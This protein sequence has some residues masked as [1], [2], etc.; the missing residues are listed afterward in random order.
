MIC[1]FNLMMPLPLILMN[2]VNKQ[3]VRENKK[4]INKFCFKGNMIFISMFELLPTS[5]KYK[6][7]G[8][9]ILFFIIG[10]LFMYINS[11]IF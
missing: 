4:F 7:R 9:T 1:Y 11:I 8:V 6:N 10:I 2:N 3:M 5:F